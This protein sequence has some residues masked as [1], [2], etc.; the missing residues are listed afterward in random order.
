MRLCAVSRV[1]RPLED[2]IRFVASPD[3][4]LVADLRHNLPGRGVWI[5]AERA[6]VAKAVAEKSFDRSLKRAI[7]RTDTL[8]DD[9]E[10]LLVKRVCDMLSL[11]N[12]AGAL[13]CGFTKVELAL[14][15]PGL[16]VLIHAA[17]AAA[18]GRD[19]LA[20]KFLAICLKPAP[21]GRIITILTTSQL[22]LAI[23]RIN[24]VHAGLTESGATEKFLFEA[25]RLE[26]YGLG[27]GAAEATSGRTIGKE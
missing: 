16:S 2:L 12:K 8:A 24:V 3:G 13:V 20:R 25:R 19:K 11:A 26:R 14:H 15:K 7:A 21:E 18:D 5:T 27:F 10:A 23:G 4:T 1:E 22:S 17:D 9:V 6:S